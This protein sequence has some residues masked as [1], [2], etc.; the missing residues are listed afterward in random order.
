MNAHDIRKAIFTAVAV[1][2]FAFPLFT[3]TAI[4]SS[5]DPNSSLIS[6]ERESINNSTPAAIYAKLQD[7]SRDICG[8]SRFSQ[9]GDLRRAAANKQCFE[10]TLTAAVQRMDDQEI[11]KLHHN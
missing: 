7:Q 6:A 4:A 11:S 2:T 1:T 5:V 10:G 9:T 8:S 3:S